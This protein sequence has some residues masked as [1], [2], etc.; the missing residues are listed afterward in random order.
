MLGRAR[1]VDRRLR[2][3]LIAHELEARV[4]ELAL[5]RRLAAQDRPHDRHVLAHLG[6]RLFDLPVVP[7]L[8]RDLVRD[9]KAQDHAA[10]ENSS[11]VAAACAIATGVREDRQHARAQPDPLADRGVRRPAR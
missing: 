7:V 9:A 8:D 1:R 6:H 2:P 5:G 11:M 4:E 10:P 3:R